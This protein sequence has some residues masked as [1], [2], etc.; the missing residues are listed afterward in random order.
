M[1]LK[2][3]QIIAIARM[4]DLAKLND[5]TKYRPLLPNQSKCQVINI[6]IIIN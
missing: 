3:H 1:Q 4:I 6:I 2:M 5:V